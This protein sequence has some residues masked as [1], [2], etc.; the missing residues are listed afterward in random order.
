MLLQYFVDLM[1]L[2]YEV[3]GNDVERITGLLVSRVYNSV[4]SAFS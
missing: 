4:S 2:T 3:H 1:G